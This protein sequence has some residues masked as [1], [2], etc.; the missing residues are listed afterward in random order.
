VHLTIINFVLVV[1]GLLL[2][3]LIKL[4][5][6]KKK[7]KGKFSIQFYFKDNAIQITTSILMAFVVMYFGDVISEGVLDV[8]IHKDSRYYEI[9]ALAAGFNNN[10]LFNE[11][12][13]K[14]NGKR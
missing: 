7:H 12:M 3:V 10:V 1:V 8:H 2:H 5:K 9:F 13:K 11:F 6:A 14:S 4:I